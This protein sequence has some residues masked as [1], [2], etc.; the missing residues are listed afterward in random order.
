MQEQEEG[1]NRF[2]AKSKPTTMNLAF[3]V[4][5]SS[6]TLN[7]PTAS[8]RKVILK[9]PCRTDWFQVQG[10]LTEEITITTQRRVLKDGK[11]CNCGR[12]Y[13]KTCRTKVFHKLQELQDWP[14][15]LHSSPNYVLPMEKVFSI[16]RQRYGRSPTDEMK[17]L[18]VNTAI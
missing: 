4:S 6:S 3:S 2:V 12:K 8:K 15:H 5:T 7:S 10:N 17:D 16:V 11:K 18:D 9:A 14:H 13:R 1:E